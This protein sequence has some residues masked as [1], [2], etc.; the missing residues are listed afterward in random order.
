MYKE[1]KKYSQLS[2]RLSYEIKSV[3]IFL[4]VLSRTSVPWNI[5]SKHKLY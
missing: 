5:S 4:E 3:P 2:D 1:K